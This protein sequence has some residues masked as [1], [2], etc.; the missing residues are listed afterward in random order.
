LN[1]FHDKNFP[2]IP[3]RVKLVFAIVVCLAAWP[4]L[5]VAGAAVSPADHGD[6]PAAAHASESP[7]ALLDLNDDDLLE[8]IQLDPSL[9]GSLSI[10]IP[11]RSILFNGVALPENPHWSIA[12]NADSWATSETI[13]A[14]QAAVDT[15][16]EIFPDS[17][18]ITIGDIS[19][20]E[21]GRLKR[22]TSHQ[23]GRDVDFGYYYK[24]GATNWFT[25]GTAKNLDLARNWAFVRALI[26]R[27][28]VEAILLDTRIQRILYQYALGI[29]EDKGWLDRIFQFARGSKEALIVHVAGHHT[30]YHVRFFNAVA[31]ALG[32]RAHPLL[33]QAGVMTPPV[34]SVQH[35]VK[36][37]QTIGQLAA[38]YG[39]T[40]RAIQD[41]NGLKTASLRAGRAYNIPRRGAAP[42]A[43]T[44]ALTVPHRMLPPSTPEPLNGV[45][46]PTNDALYG[47]PA[48][49]DK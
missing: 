37:G 16:F 19:A 20:R 6:R 11:R 29:G 8:R 33:V 13:A 34:Y 12:R 46:W 32:R 40:V 2:L 14:I 35:V 30:H 45:E 47:L 31:Q 44:Q 38:R 28:D 24:D 7:A 22:H 26:T 5:G 9:L 27:T 39:T 49:E 43:T 4:L 36:A 3:M 18:A 17:P 1:R 48:A 42:P 25:P 23:G 15:V 10:G 41:A 21:G